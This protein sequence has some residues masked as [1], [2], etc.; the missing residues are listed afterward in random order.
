MCLDIIPLKSAPLEVRLLR[1][2]LGSSFKILKQTT[3]VILG[4]F[5]SQLQSH[6]LVILIASNLLRD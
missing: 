5:S 1:N 3:S 2:K 4:V 6:L